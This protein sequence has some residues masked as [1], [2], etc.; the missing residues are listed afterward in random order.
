MPISHTHV[1]YTF[2]NSQKKYLSFLVKTKNLLASKKSPLLPVGIDAQPPNRNFGGKLRK[3]VWVNNSNLL[4]S[5]HWRFR[6][7]IFSF[8]E[9]IYIWLKIFKSYAMIIR[10]ILWVFVFL[11]HLFWTHSAICYNILNEWI[12]RQYL[13]HLFLFNENIQMNETIC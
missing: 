2:H 9:T 5:V 6:P 10:G 4:Q 12:I 1:W 13:L 3:I 8:P 11:E 7:S